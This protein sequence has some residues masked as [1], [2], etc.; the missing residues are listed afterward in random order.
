MADQNL[1]LHVNDLRIQDN[2]GLYN[3]AKDKPALSIYVFDPRREDR[4]GKNRLDFRRKNIEKLH[5]VYK[6][7][8]SGLIVKK[9]R[10]ENVL[11]ELK[12]ETGFDEVYFNREYDPINK[13]ILNRVR[14][15]FSFE[16]F[17]DRVAV[18]P[19]QLSQEYRT[20]SPF[21]QEWKEKLKIQTVGEPEKLAD[22]DSNP[23]DFEVES[24]IEMPEPGYEAGKRR[25]K[26]FLDRIGRYK[27]CRDDVGN[28]ESVSR[29]SPYISNGLIS[30]SEILETVLELMEESSDSDFIRN[31]AKYRSELAWREFFY[32]VLYHNPSALNENYKD[33]GNEIKWKDDEKEFEAW[34]SG[35]TGVPF[36][37]AGIRE[38]RET[39]YMHNRTRQNVASFLSKHLMI[40]W[41]KG[42]K[43]FRKHLFDHDFA[44]NNGGWQWSASTG[45]DSVP[46]RIFNPV[47][48]GRKYD[49]ECE[50]IKRWI[51]ELRDL[52]PNS[53]HGWVEMSSKERS[54]FDTDY[55]EPIINFNKRYHMGKKM[56]E[57]AL[58]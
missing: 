39:G 7:K 45:T 37:D 26:S 58:E 6:S 55:P 31:I 13:R 19:Q 38:L 15:G 22:I 36:V 33:F 44:N 30:V 14:E 50:Y 42:A 53:I 28:P 4:L 27:D 9:G 23:V 40:D 3:A 51:P 41:R 48:Q 20:Y 46:V 57:A 18:E 10:T 43:F 29:M 56:F 11:S 49:T 34:K 2:N 35:M 47:K 16:S 12:K 24:S 25:F 8:G 17:K 52:D 1:F 54:E 32:Q 21:Y 5:R